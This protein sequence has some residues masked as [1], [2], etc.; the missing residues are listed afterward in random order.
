VFTLKWTGKANFEGEGMLC[1]N[2]LIGDYHD[3]KK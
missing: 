1:D 3:V 2:I